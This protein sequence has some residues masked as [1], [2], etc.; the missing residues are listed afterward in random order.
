[1]KEIEVLEAA[2]GKPVH[3][4]NASDVLKLYKE[5]SNE[6]SKYYVLREIAKER[7]NDR[8]IY[9]LVAPRLQYITYMS[10]VKILTAVFE[11]YKK[12]DNAKLTRE[13]GKNLK[14]DIIDVIK[15]CD[16]EL[17]KLMALNLGLRFFPK[18]EDL[19][20]EN[21][22]EL[23]TN[24]I[25]FL[26]SFDFTKNL[27]L[28]IQV[29]QEVIYPVRLQYFKSFGVDLFTSELLVLVNKFEEYINAVA[30]E[31]INKRKEEGGSK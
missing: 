15:T 16:I 13:E 6:T 1:M 4:W 18:D 12:E 5:H 8:D 20:L 21:A 29:M 3:E 30:E 19:K 25:K 26:F 31:V 28:V 23:I 10:S 11:K 22:Q 2:C 17:T 9:E 14:Q 7:V 24:V 27:S